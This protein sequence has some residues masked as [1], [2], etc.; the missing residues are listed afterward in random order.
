MSSLKINQHM[1][2]HRAHRDVPPSQCTWTCQ[3]SDIC[4][5]AALP[6]ICGEAF[7][8]D[9]LTSVPGKSVSLSAPSCKGRIRPFI[10]LHVII[11]L[12]H[13]SAGCTLNHFELILEFRP[14]TLWSVQK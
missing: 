9:L 10:F 1:K 5:A 8:D 3:H 2:A 4:I 6:C 13:S 12:N 7:I 11:I 14:Q